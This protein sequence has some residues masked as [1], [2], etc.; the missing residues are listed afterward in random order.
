ME[1]N[2]WNSYILKAKFFKVRKVTYFCLSNSTIMKLRSLTI[3]ISFLL[4]METFQAQISLSGGTCMLNSFGVKKAFYG[5]HFGG[6]MPQNNQVTFYGRLSYFFP[7]VEE[8]SMQAVAVGNNSNVT[9]YAIQVNYVN[10]TNFLII[11]GGTR[12]YF[13]NGFDNGFS[14]YGGGKTSLMINKINSRFAKFDKSK[15]SIEESNL[16]NGSILSIC[17]GLQGGLKYTMPA[18]GTIFLDASLNYILFAAPSNQNISTSY[19]PN[20]RILFVTSLGFRK[21]FY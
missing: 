12:S 21:D 13:G 15:Y 10:S 8:D 4:G 7:R 14:G 19:F 2:L 9:P 18:I 17:L 3:L 16:G 11:E 6:E 20:Q 5:L 1:K